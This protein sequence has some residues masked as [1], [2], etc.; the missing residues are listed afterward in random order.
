MVAKLLTTTIAAPGFKGVNTQ[1][2]SIT[3]EDGFATVANNCVID[4]FGRIGSRKGWIAAHTTNTDLGT[5]SVKA[6]D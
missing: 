4:K 5:A 6:I 1:D 3:L 2:S